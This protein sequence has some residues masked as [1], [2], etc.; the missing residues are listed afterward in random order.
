VA[1][2]ST[3]ALPLPMIQLLRASTSV[4]ASFAHDFEY[5]GIKD[6][7]ILEM[8]E[9]DPQ[10]IAQCVFVACQ[11]GIE[12]A[13]AQFASRVP[14]HFNHYLR[15]IDTCLLKKQRYLDAAQ[16]LLITAGRYGWSYDLVNFGEKQI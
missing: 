15:T 14:L 10:L 8:T 12:V 16:S 2:S 1:V 13:S 9:E 5:Y 4:F 11:E 7:T 3:A 6:R